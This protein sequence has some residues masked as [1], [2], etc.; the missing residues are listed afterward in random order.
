VRVS[1]MPTTTERSAVKRYC[2]SVMRTTPC[3]RGMD[4]AAF[5]AALVLTHTRNSRSVACFADRTTASM[6]RH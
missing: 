2:V 3:S 1:E 5:S 4:Y 6:S